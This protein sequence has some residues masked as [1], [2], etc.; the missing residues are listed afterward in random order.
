MRTYFQELTPTAVLR[1]IAQQVLKVTRF[2]ARVMLELFIGHDEVIKRSDKEVKQS[3][4][5]DTISRLITVSN[6]V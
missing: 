1:R 3:T 5:D 6:L 2:V 4:N